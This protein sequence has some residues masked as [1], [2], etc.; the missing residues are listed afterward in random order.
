MYRWELYGTQGCHLCEEAAALVAPLLAAR[1]EEWR[2]VDIAF[3]EVLSARYGVRIPVL[4][5]CASGAEL[6]WPFDATQLAAWV[7]GVSE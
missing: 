6:G 3:D 5:H 1:G 7:Q 4:R 2:E